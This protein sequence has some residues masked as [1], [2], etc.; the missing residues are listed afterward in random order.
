M[1]Q[2]EIVKNFE[3]EKKLYEQTSADNRREIREIFN[4]YL[5]KE[6][7]NK[8][9]PY[10]HHET[11]PKLRTEISY[12]KP[13]IFSGTPEFTCEAI[14]DED[15]LVANVL[16]KIL[17]FRISSSIKNAYEKIE[18]WVHQGTTFGTSVIQV[19]WRTEL[20][21]EPEMD[22][23]GNP[24]MD[25]EGN[26]V[27]YQLVTRDEPDLEVPNILDV[28]RNPVIAEVYQQPSMIFRALLPVEDVKKCTVYDYTDNEG[29]LN[30]EKI[31]GKKISNDTYNSSS[32]NTDVKEAFENQDGMVEVFERITKESIQTIAQGLVLREVENPYGMINAVKWVFEKN[33]IPNRFDGFGVGHN[34]KGLGTLYY[35]MFN[36][37][38][39]SV[40][41]ANNP[42]FLYKKGSIGDTSKLVGKPGGGI[43]VDADDINDAIKP[44]IFPDVKQGMSMVLQK[45]DDEHKRASGASNLIQGATSNETLGQDQI[46]MNST[47][48]RFELIQRRFR[49]ALA[50]V[51]EMLLTMELKNLQSS[52]AEILRIFP[53]ELREE[54]YQLLITERDNVKFNVRVRGETVVSRDKNMESKRLVELFNLSQNF[55]TD[56]EKR[57]FVRRIAERQGEQQLD[58]IIAE[59][60]P[61][62]QQ[63]MM[64]DQQMM[65]GIGANESPQ[66]VNQ[67]V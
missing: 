2:D 17:N 34:T 12:I 59:E 1:T 33:T 32:Q 55:L 16:E 63:G 27:M 67:N 52:D 54:I 4:S 38:L 61:M 46:A 66:A 21:E 41:L 51:G 50:D 42:M 23:E 57:A 56:T 14:G 20:K 62:P 53:E 60:A 18:D 31:E 35:K 6:D 24:L 44:I 48:N 43:P 9:L 45:I 8:K 49:Q 29:I 37:T 58:E 28:Y 64:P 10:K 15:K 26:P 13:Y 65:G 5:G 47:T 39:D 36:Q 3:K 40:A 30:R 7:E 11:I 25:E 19:V 22:G